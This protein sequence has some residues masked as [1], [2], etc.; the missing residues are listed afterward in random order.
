M[1]QTLLMMQRCISCL[2]CLAMSSLLVGYH[3]EKCSCGSCVL[4]LVHVHTYEQCC[5]TSQHAVHSKHDG[6]VQ[7]PS[8]LASSPNLK[9]VEVRS[10]T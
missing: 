7:A 4:Q 9:L 1:T 5:L 8:V 6:P 2:C 3:T 10:Q